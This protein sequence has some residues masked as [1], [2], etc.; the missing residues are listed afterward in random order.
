MTS[1]ADVIRHAPD[2]PGPA[3]GSVAIMRRG[4]GPDTNALWFRLLLVAAAYYVSARL[5]LR[6]ALVGDIVTPLWPPT[7]LA[8]VALFALGLGVWPAIAVAAFV[9]NLPLAG[10]PAVAA[11]I[12]VGNTLAPL[13]AVLLLQRLNFDGRLAR[14]RDAVTLVFTALVSMTIS[15]T[16]GTLSVAA[17]GT[18]LRLA[19]AWW[20]W[21]AGDAMGVLIVAPLLWR[22]SDLRG[23][24]RGSIDPGRAVEASLLF[25]AL[26]V[27]AYLAPRGENSFM[28]TVLPL[29]GWIAWRFQQSGAAPAGFIASSLVILAA[30]DGGGVFTGDSV[31]VR[32]VII[33]AFNA[34]VAL[35]S[36]VFAA[37]VTERR[38]I[39]ESLYLREHRVAQTL[40]RN[41]LPDALPDVPGVAICARYVPAEPEAVVGGDWYDV[42]RFSDDRLGVV[43]GDVAGHGIASAAAM[44]QLRT[45]LRAHALMRGGPAAALLAVNRLSLELH[46]GT[47]ATV[48]YAEFDPNRGELRMANAGHPRPLLIS[49]TGEGTYLDGGRMLP[50]GVTE[51]LEPREITVPLAEGSTLLLFTDGLVER[52]LESIDVSLERLRRAASEHRGGLDEFCDHVIA[53]TAIDG[54][55][56][57]ALL[58]LRPTSLA[59]IALHVERPALPTGV[60][61]VRHVMQRWLTANGANEEEIADV[62]VAV[63]EAQT[64]AVR[65]AY[66][67]REGRVSIDASVE[68]DVLTVTVSDQGTWQHEG[69]PEDDHGGRGL[70][71]IRALVDLEVETSLAGTR[72]RMQRR[73]SGTR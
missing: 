36:F 73:L 9:V 34:S 59:G 10:S 50:I 23:V 25:S 62:L 15:A 8:V 45:G 38:Q 53:A 19:D 12:A 71:L 27:L 69:A 35:T 2:G 13:W 56:D 58:T 26:T 54:S 49:P 48:L 37:A 14:L 65:H 51:D 47:L 1:G 60:A 61:E 18:S 46:P 70:S 72:L 6:F 64:N 20:V 4:R 67:T 7:G 52:R 63:S 33:Q 39:L 24:G 55:D 30:A 11:G 3:T 68:G 29:L 31:Q 32:M 40:Q 17:G 21:W 44:A 5:G 66:R 42:I 16:V 57:V 43:V 41:L 28:F 22:A